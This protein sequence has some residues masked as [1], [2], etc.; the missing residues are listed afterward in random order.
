MVYLRCHGTL[1]SVAIRP[2]G[3][4]HP[5]YLVSSKNRGAGPQPG[6][7]KF[8]KTLC[9]EIFENIVKAPISLVVK[10][11]NKLQSFCIR[12]KI[13]LVAALPWCVDHLVENLFTVWPTLLMAY[14]TSRHINI[15]VCLSGVGSAG[16]FHY[17]SVFARV[18]TTDLLRFPWQRTFES[19][20]IFCG[21]SASN[22][23]RCPLV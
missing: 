22:L 7:S 15:I 9:L 17:L 13:H 5:H 21:M 20:N 18:G 11:N 19:H 4:C 6:A 12:R 16:K 10:Y 8:L 3:R 23:F 14:H 1:N 2:F